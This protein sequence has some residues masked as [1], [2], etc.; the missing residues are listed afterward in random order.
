MT[1]LRLEGERVAEYSTD[2]CWS[3]QS[4]AR[5]HVATYI[6]RAGHT[7]GPMLAP[8]NFDNQDQVQ[9]GGRLSP[10]VFGGNGSILFFV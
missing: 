6:M 5:G 9:G 7:P 2:R 10:F 1:R 4:H 8:I 3:V